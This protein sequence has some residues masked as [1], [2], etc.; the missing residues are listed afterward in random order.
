MRMRTIGW[1]AT[2]GTLGILLGTW[3]APAAAAQTDGVAAPPQISVGQRAP[4]APVKQLD[5]TPT[6]LDHYLGVKPVVI[7]FW[8]KWCGNCRALEPAIHAARVTFGNRITII[9]L[10][11]AV[12]ETPADVARYVRAHDI[13]PD[14][15][16]DPTGAAVDAY[17][18]PGTSFVVVVNRAGTVVYTG[19]GADQNLDAAIRRAL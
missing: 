11:V 7:E 13:P 5:G 15:V 3:M 4:A 9:T 12:D 18:A 1:A 8:G 19:S 10:A 6:D 14:V 17:G 2:T 16:F